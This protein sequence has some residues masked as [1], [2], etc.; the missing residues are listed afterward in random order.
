[1]MENNG[2]SWDV[3]LGMHPMPETFMVYTTHCDF[4]DVLLLGFP[5]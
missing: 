5:Q 2:T 3:Q 4:G 1:M